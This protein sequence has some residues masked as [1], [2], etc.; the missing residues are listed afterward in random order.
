[1]RFCLPAST[2]LRWTAIAFLGLSPTIAP[3]ANLFWDGTGTSWNTAANWSTVNNATTPN[4]GSPPGAADVANFNIT[5]VNTAQTV[6]LDAAQSALGLLFTSTGTVLI[7]TGAGSNTLT[8]GASGITVNAGAG[9]DTI[10][11]AVNLGTS[12]AWTNNS[13]NTLTVSGNVNNALNLLTVAGTGSTTISGMI[14]GSG[15][16]TKNGTATLILGSTNSFT[17]PITV[18]GG[19]LQFGI[20]GTLSAGGS[21][22]L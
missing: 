5:T 3:A 16:L 22:S 10:S 19:T 4:P 7:Q 9:A 18:G 1:M 12:Q 20:A 8:L 6:N 14:S 13:V 11:A 21:I 17:G 15:G 2:V